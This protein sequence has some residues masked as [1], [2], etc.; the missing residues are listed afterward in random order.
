MAAAPVW[1]VDP[2]TGKRRERVAVEATADEVDVVVR[3][4]HAVRVSLADRS[5]RAGFLR[6]AAGA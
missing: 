4:A 1:S 2:R 6:S 3:A 5:V